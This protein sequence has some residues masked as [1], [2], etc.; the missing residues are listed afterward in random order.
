M[1]NRNT[2]IVRLRC[3]SFL[4]S[5]LCVSPC[6]AGRISALAY[7]NLTDGPNQMASDD[8]GTSVMAS[9]ASD[10]SYASAFANTD[11]L[12]RTFAA[13]SEMGLSIPVSGSSG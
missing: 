7:I 6:F 1:S 8:P 9:A 11:L 3:L 5:L 10:G 12:F 4:I 2:S 13:A